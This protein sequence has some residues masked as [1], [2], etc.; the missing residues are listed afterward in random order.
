LEKWPVFTS[1]IAGNVALS[2][3][4]KSGGMLGAL[5]VTIIQADNIPVMDSNGLCDPYVKVSVNAA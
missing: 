4:T 5:S 2:S 1:L 3:A